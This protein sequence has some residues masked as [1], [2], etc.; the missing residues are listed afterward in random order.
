MQRS[1][2]P[3]HQLAKIW[4]VL[5]TS[6]LT[7]EF[8]TSWHLGS[9]QTIRR[10]GISIRRGSWLLCI[11]SELLSLGRSQRFLRPCQGLFMKLLPN[12]RLFF[13][14]PFPS[15]SITYEAVFLLFFF[16]QI[17][18]STSSPG[19][20]F[21]TPRGPETEPM[22]EGTVDSAQ[23]VLDEFFAEIRGRETS[24]TSPLASPHFATPSDHS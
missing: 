8:V 2:L 16:P 15:D 12:L 17:P 24:T 3:N 5:Y 22:R 13:M 4:C 14:N 10:M 1:R 21:I 20:R 7:V 19:P 9:W 6:F 11:S 18:L 23:S